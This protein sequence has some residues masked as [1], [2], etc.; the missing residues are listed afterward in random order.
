MKKRVR[1][2]NII[3]ITRIKGYFGIPKGDSN[4]PHTVLMVERKRPNIPTHRY[5]R[6]LVFVLSYK[7]PNKPKAIIN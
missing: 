1:S 3:E 2:L 5:I 6:M 7:T 4:A